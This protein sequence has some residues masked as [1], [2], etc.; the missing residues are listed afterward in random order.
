MSGKGENREREDVL[1]L[2]QFTDISEMQ[3][4]VGEERCSFQ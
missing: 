2:L 3:V 1:M 4:L